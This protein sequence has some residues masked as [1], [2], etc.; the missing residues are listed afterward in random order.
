MELKD[1][2]STALIDIVEGVQ[3]SKKLLG[4]NQNCI[5]PIVKNCM[6][7]S[8]LKEFDHT[9]GLH[10]KT[11]HF[12]VAVTIENKNTKNGKIGI[13]VCGLEAGIG[14]AGDAAYSSTSR[15]KFDIPI[16]FKVE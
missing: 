13:K 2:I 15:I 9:Q 5:C 11:V 10:H 4:E 1:F 6:G 3:E 8:S 16:A 7:G 14:K 12:D